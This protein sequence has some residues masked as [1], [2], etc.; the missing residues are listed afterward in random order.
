METLQRFKKV[1]EEQMNAVG[2][3]IVA[4]CV[5]FLQ[6]G[7]NPMLVL[8]ALIRCARVVLRKTSREDQK[9]ILPVL[10]A[11]LEGRT[12]PPGSGMLWTPADGPAN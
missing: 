1:D 3:A 8:L 5:P 4:A 7:T 11:Y 9:E 10:N 12:Q 2:K 6:N